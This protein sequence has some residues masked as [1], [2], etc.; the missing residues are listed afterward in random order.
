MIHC[1]RTNTVNVRALYE[2]LKPYPNN[3]NLTNIKFAVGGLA[4]DAVYF[5]FDAPDAD[6]IMTADFDFFVAPRNP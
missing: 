3:Q 1:Y 5:V 6:G 2:Q 4:Y